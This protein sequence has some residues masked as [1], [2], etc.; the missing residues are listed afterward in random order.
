MI[1]RLSL[2]DQSVDSLEGW[3]TEA[4]EPAYRSRQILKWVD[5]LQ[6]ID[7][8]S[9]LPAPLRELLKEKFTDEYIDTSECIE[10]EDEGT[11]RFLFR[12]KDGEAVE[13]VQ[14]GAPEDYTACISTQVGCGLRCSFCASGKFGLVRNLSPGE[15]VG[16]ILSLRK[17]ISQRHG[18][19]GWPRH[20]VYMGMGEPFQNYQATMDSIRRLIDPQGINFG[21][22]R[23]TVSTVG[24]VPEIYRFAEEDLQVGLAVSLHAPNSDLRKSIM[25][26][27]EVYPLSR[28]FPACEKYIEKTGRRLTFEYILLKDINDGPKEA[29][30]LVEIFKSWK[31]V[32]FNLIRYNPIGLTRLR[33]PSP[34]QAKAFLH[35][36]REGGLHVTLRQSPGKKI[37][38]A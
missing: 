20:I 19:D 3:L 21:V 26:I 37:N 29:K 15:I 2:L 9:D 25:P 33:P 7:S 11:N 32:H 31:L 18:V 28:L 38:A 30:K 6:P 22:R 12:L 24:L 35:R 23:I 1:E 17:V 36:L 16:Q 10:S 5:Q 14:I 4:G 27:E 13:S 34:P 8:M